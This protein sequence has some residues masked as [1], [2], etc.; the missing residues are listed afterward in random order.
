VIADVFYQGGNLVPDKNVTV[1]SGMDTKD[2]ALAL[3]S[4]RLRMAGT[5]QKV[6]QVCMGSW[7]WLVFDNS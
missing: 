4:E 5:L 7:L 1:P 2:L 6:L 3:M